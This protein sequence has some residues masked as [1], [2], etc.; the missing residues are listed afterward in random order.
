MRRVNTEPAR[1]L[2]R[3]RTDA[4]CLL[5]FRLRDRRLAGR[6]FKRQFAIDRFIV[7]FFCADAKPIVELDG[8]RHDQNSERDEDR[9]GSLESMGYLVLRVWNHDVMRDMDAVLAEILSTVNQQRAEP[10]HPGPLPVGEREQ[11]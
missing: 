3:R 11:S 1:Q 7:D 8:G 6:K 2:R 9:T 5:W 10:P 4:E